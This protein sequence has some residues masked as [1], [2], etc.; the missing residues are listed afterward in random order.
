MVHRIAQIAVLQEIA[1]ERLK[2]LYDGVG[3][4]D[5]HGAGGIAYV[6][7]LRSRQQRGCATI[8]QINYARAGD[9]FWNLAQLAEIGR[10]L[11]EKNVHADLVVECHAIQRLLETVRRDGIRA[12]HDHGVSLARVKRRLQL[13]CHL[14]NA[15]DGFARHMATALGKDLILD[16]EAAHARTF[17]HPN[18]S[19]DIGDIAKAGIAIGQDRDFD[20]VRYPGIV[21]AQLSQ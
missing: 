16:E 11:N 15:N 18:S 17:Q 12:R 10:R 8:D 13:A 19:S 7:A 5:G 21:V 1:V 3:G 4:S 14:F 6:L 9:L 20:P 2:R